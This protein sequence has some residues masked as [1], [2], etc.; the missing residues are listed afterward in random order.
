MWNAECGIADRRVLLV[1]N[2]A[3]RVPHSAIQLP[4]VLAALLKQL[5][6]L[7]VV[8]RRKPISADI[9]Q[10]GHDF[11]RRPLEKSLHYVSKGSGP[12]FSFR[13]D[14][15]IGVVVA[16]PLVAYMT[17]PFQDGQKRTHCGIAGGIR[18]VLHHFQGSRFPCPI[19]NIHD[20]A[21]APGQMSKLVR[22]DKPH[23]DRDK[24]GLRKL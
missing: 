3:I 13:S 5:K 21:F 18:N 1:F 16:V 23:R 22:H 14:G 24:Y 6:N 7:R 4:P 2:S 19:Q 20:L 12:R 17:L 9:N 15:E 8:F 10:R 11:G